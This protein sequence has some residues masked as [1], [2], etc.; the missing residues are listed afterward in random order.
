MT[1]YKV[2]KEENTMTIY[3]ELSRH[4]FTTE[5][6]EASINGTDFSH[7]G[8]HALYYY[9]K[10]QSKAQGAPIIFEKEEIHS[11]WFEGDLRDVLSALR[12][13][14]LEN[15]KERTQVIELSGERIIYKSFYLV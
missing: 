4:A 6:R 14:T 10:K 13:S 2:I 3:K 8:T 5:L 1:I 12:I 15:L 9:L 7:E 11:D